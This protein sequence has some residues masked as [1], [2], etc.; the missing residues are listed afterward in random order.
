MISHFV[1]TSG[2]RTIAGSWLPSRW[3]RRYRA[4]MRTGISAWVFLLLSCASSTTA[5]QAKAGPAAGPS[6]EGS[7]PT[8]TAFLDLGSS[9]TTKVGMSPQAIVAG[10]ADPAIV[11]TSSMQSGDTVTRRMRLTRRQ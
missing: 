11:A 5:A 2:F 4:P 6:H 10:A 9:M 1:T 8:G 7:G 3:R